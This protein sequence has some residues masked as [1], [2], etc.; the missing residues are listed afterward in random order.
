MYFSCG[1]V[2]VE[3]WN[4]H[5]LSSIGSPIS[6]NLLFLKWI[7]QIIC[8]VPMIWQGVFK[9]TVSLACDL[10][11][12]LLVSLHSKE[13]G[14]CILAW[15]SCLECYF[16]D[17]CINF[18][19]E[20]VKNGQSR[21]KPSSPHLRSAVT[22]LCTAKVTTP[23]VLG[24]FP[25]RQVTVA[26]GGDGRMCCVVA[27]AKCDETAASVRMSQRDGEIVPSDDSGD[28]IPTRP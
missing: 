3:V 24:G 19:F 13:D 7:P 9:T 28:E 20:S 27:H 15:R 26:W 21:V 1:V 4:W 11:N 16:C 17:V 23:L 5:W 12:F 22:S 2:W 8:I 18:G 6:K 14:R 10:D 25:I